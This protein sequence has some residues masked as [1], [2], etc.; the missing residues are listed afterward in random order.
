[1][2]AFTQRS[3]RLLLVLISQCDGSH[4]GFFNLTKLLILR[5]SVPNDFLV[6]FHSPN[7]ETDTLLKQLMLTA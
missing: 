3:A 6:L 4:R 5:L 1:M 2:R 7:S